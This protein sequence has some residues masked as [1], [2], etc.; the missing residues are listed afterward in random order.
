MLVGGNFDL[1]KTW[2]FRAEVGFIGRYSVLLNTVYRLN[3]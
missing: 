2:S 1:G 3:F